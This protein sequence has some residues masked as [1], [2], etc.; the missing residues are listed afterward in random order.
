MK[1]VQNFYDENAQS[2]WE[3]LE[4][5]HRTEYAV[6]LRALEEFLPSAP[7]KLIDIGGGP[8]RYAIPLAGQG[9]GVML[10]D[11]SAGNLAFAQ[12]KA[13]EAGLKLSGYI[14][15][16][17]L[18][19]SVFPA[20]S[21]DVALL[22]GPLYHLHT[23]AERHQALGGAHRLLKPGGLIFAAVITRFAP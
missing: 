13:F 16:N 22:M 19:L 8:G 5:R 17:A 7:A 4:V 20:E 2:E 18:D 15:A 21:F 1:N 6:T 3:R 12:Q 9:Y 11:L 10:V 14:H 23:E